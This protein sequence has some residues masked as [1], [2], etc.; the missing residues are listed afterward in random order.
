MKGAGK[1]NK[2]ISR[3]LLTWVNDWENCACVAFWMEN[4]IERIDFAR[5]Q[6]FVA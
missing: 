3:L 1:G 6:P 2:G 5:R 4:G